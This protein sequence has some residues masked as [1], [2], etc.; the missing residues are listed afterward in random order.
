METE[1]A[2]QRK[3][4]ARQS[5]QSV[6]PQ[7]QREHSTPALGEQSGT[8]LIDYKALRRVDP[9]AARHVVLDYLENTGHNIAATASDEAPAPQDGAELSVAHTNSSREGPP[10]SANSRRL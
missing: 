3:R 9:V 4:T 6:L 8:V 2:G 1:R 10:T 7:G 5:Q